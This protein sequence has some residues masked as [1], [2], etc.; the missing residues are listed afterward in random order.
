M[1]QLNLLKKEL[2]ARSLSLGIGTCLTGKEITK[3]EMELSYH[4]ALLKHDET[5]RNKLGYHIYKEIS[6]IGYKK[7]KRK[8]ISLDFTLSIG[9]GE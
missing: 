3:Y 1:R 2:G 5:I 8:S 6:K 7:P 9:E 4:W